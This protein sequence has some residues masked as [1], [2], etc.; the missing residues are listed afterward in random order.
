MQGQRPLELILARNLLASLSTPAVL[1]DDRGTVVFYN[2]AAGRVLGQRFEESGPMSAR[3]WGET[4][5]PFHESGE[6]IAYEELDLPKQMLKGQAGHSQFHIRSLDG[7]M[8]LIEA[9][10]LPIV[11]AGGQRGGMTFF[12]E[13]E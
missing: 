5:G 10:G 4:H 2:E 9:S 1:T 12:W 13:A 7:Q 11:A 3:Q 6:R 8:R